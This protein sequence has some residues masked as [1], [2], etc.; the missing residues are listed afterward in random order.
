MEQ[1]RWSWGCIGPIL[2]A[3]L[4]NVFSWRAVF[5]IN[6]PFGLI[7]L[8]LCLKKVNIKPLSTKLPSI[9]FLGQLTGTL[10]IGLLILVFLK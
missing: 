9:D 8:A 10:S 2:G 3:Y 1:Y 6:I 4:S 5:F 7:A